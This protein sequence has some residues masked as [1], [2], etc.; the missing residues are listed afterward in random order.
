ML[1]ALFIVT[2]TSFVSW[3]FDI[4]FYL[5]F[6]LMKVNILPKLSYSLGQVGAGLPVIASLR[7]IISSGDPVHRIVGSLSGNGNFQIFYILLLC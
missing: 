2:F 5:F 6:F 1:F 4:P 7:R 3:I